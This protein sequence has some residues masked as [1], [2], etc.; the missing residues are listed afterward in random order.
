MPRNSN[1]WLCDTL[2]REDYPGCERK[3][4]IALSCHVEGRQ[5]ALCRPCDATWK[6]KASG[7]AG[8][9]L[10][11]PLCVHIFLATEA[12]APVPQ[13]PARQDP[14]VHSAPLRGPLADVVDYAMYAEGLLIDVRGRVLRRMASDPRTKELLNP[15]AEVK[16]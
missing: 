1:D 8:V 15:P 6:K 11:C 3:A 16:T 7:N 13:A 12:G 9:S 14:M 5:Y 10:R 4:V 2:G